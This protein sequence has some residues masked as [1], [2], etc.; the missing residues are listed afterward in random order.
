STYATSA[1]PRSAS[2]MAAMRVVSSMV[3]RAASI[4]GDTSLVRIPLR[5]ASA[6]TRSLSRAP[7]DRATVIVRYDIDAAGAKPTAAPWNPITI[8]FDWGGAGRFAIVD[9]ATD[10]NA[11]RSGKREN[12]APNGLNAIDVTMPV[13]VGPFPATNDTDAPPIC[14]LVTVTT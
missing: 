3:R 2:M 8:G 12:V 13:I 14:E 1:S 4:A 9:F 6:L 11:P 7:A 5:D 10:A